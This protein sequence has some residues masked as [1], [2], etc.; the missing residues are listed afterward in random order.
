M[1]LQQLIYKDEILRERFDM[2]CEISDPSGDLTKTLKVS[3]TR[4]LA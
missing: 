2:K 3:H 4:T 1:E